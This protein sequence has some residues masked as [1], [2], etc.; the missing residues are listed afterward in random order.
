MGNGQAIQKIFG[1]PK[2]VIGMIHLLPLPGSPR[3][4]GDTELILE[5]AVEEALTYKKEGIHGVM[6]E[7][8]HDRPYPKR[9][10]DPAVT[11]MTAVAARLVKKE[12]GLPTGIQI[13]AGANKEALAAALA[14]GADFIRAEGFVFAHVADEGIIEADAGSLLRYRRQIGA[15][16]IAVFADIKKKHAAHTLTGDTS[17]ADHARAAAFF[18]AD[19]LVV[20]GTET[21]RPAEPQDVRSVREAVTLP[22][23]VG[24]GL[25]PDNLAY[26]FPFAHGFIAGSWMKRDGRWEN[27]VDRRRVRAFMDAFRE[28]E[29]SNREGHV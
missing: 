15:G 26:Y 19:G 5:R 20:T 21:G 1:R 17:L 13:L 23:L 10:A 14:A 29:S 25:T 11:A 6:L 9:T 24:S 2:A 4:G 27:P 7:N 16:H 3:Y 22:V 8:M 12:T 18:L 28:L